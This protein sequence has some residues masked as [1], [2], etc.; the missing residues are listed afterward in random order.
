MH[1]PVKKLICVDCGC[2]FIFKGRTRKLR[3]DKCWIPWRNAYLK[4]RDLLRTLRRGGKPGVGSGGNQWG[5]NNHSWKPITEHKSTKY[6]GN[7]RSRCFKFWGNGCILCNIIK[8]INV[9]HVDGNPDN[10]QPENLVPL[11]FNHHI[12]GIHYKKWTTEQEY[13]DAFVEVSKKVAQSKIAE[14]NGNAEKP[15]RGEG[16]DQN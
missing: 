3:C 4:S 14:K 13:L 9:H 16:I 7:Y 6:V 15:I 1:V 11:C 5:K 12:N 10:Y 8:N 2:L